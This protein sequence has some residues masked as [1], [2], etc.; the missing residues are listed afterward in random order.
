MSD[1]QVTSLLQQ[2]IAAVKAGDK[3]LA[4]EFL[5]QVVDLD[6]RNEQGWLWLS[7]VVEMIEDRRLCLENVL[8]VNPDS[9]PALAG[10]R[11]IEQQ[12]P[13]SATATEQGAASVEEDAALAQA[14]PSTQEVCPRC[15]APVSASAAECANCGLP[16]IVACPS[17]GEYAEIHQTSCTNCGQDLGDFRTGTGYFLALAQAY[18]TARRSERAQD[19][20]AQALKEAPDDPQVLEECSRMYEQLG[21]TD[22]AIAV[23]QQ[24]IELAPGN[25]DLTARLGALYR[26]TMRP[27]EARAMY[28][29]AVEIAGDDKEILIELAS[30]YLE[31]GGMDKEA[32]KLLT[33]VTKKDPGNP[34]AHLLLGD[35][36]Y[37]QMQMD[38]AF[39]HYSQ[40]K[41]LSPLDSE[42][43]L[44][45]EQRLA[46]LQHSLQTQKSPSGTGSVRRS[47]PRQR[48]GCL[49]IY[50]ILLGIGGAFGLLGVILAGLALGLGGDML[51]ETM[52]YVTELGML[53]INFSMFWLSLGIGFVAAIIN[54]ALA[55]GLWN[56][57]NWARITAIVLQAISLL[58]TIVQ[59][60]FTVSAA[61]LASASAGLEGVPIPILCGVLFGFVVSGYIIFWF[62]ANGELF[63]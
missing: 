12:A 1:A 28:E 27:A 30:L 52:R 9:A 38:Q 57:K 33:K 42:T 46:K 6:E 7:G 39:R 50:A 61:R 25:A 34:R 45:A 14:A 22:L 48:P 44:A 2:G 24:A 31:D 15:E 18:L 4:R 62:I 63:D 37:N 60:V 49:T 13:E 17:C 5:M 51:K 53:S 54:L 16:L 59:G 36:Y 43:G 26:Q 35:V 29:K 21:Q 19:A 3:E 8:A 32:Q 20:I 41:A 58:A 56:L 11:W 47:T 40:A 23:C 55:V 10:L